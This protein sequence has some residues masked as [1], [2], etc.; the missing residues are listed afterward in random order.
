[1]EKKM[2]T[3]FEMNTYSKMSTVIQKG[4]FWLD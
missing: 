1:M 2:L 4:I 3:K